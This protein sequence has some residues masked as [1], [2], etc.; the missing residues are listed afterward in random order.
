[1]RDAESLQLAKRTAMAFHKPVD[2]EDERSDLLYRMGIM[3][4]ISEAL[5]KGKKMLE[6]LAKIDAGR[7]VAG[8]GGQPGE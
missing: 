6:D 2:L 4:T 8:S 3:P 7:E 5:E 1:M